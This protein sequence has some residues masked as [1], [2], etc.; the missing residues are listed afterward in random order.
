MSGTILL[1]IDVETTG[2][3]SATYARHGPDLLAAE[4]I[5]ATWYVTGQSLERDPDLFIAADRSGVVDLQSHTYSHMLLKTVLI[6]APPGRLVCGAKDWFLK[7]GGTNEEIDQDLARCQKLFRDVLGRPAVGLCGPWNYYRGLG[8]RPDLLEITHR[9]GFRILRTAGRN[10]QD[11][12]PV[13][14]EW[15][16]YFYAV[17]GF[18]IGRAH[19]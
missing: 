12:L 5:R 13:P 17:Q 11:Y 1:G 10:E 2:A 18:Q 16:P 7:R 15:Q 6:Q 4:G 8:D 19:V 9:H 14:L 3:A